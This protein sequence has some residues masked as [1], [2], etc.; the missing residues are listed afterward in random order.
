M[1][2]SAIPPAYIVYLLQ[3]ERDNLVVPWF[4]I[5]MLCGLVWSISFGLIALVESPILRFV[6]TNVVRV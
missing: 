6:I 5:S 4:Q 2:V 1:L 3:N